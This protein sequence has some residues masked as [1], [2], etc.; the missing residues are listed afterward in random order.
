LALLGCWLWLYHDLF[1]Y[2]GTLVVREDF[3][4]N[5]M[6]LVAIVGLLLWRIAQRRLTLRVDQAPQLVL[7]PLLLLIS[8]SVGY[9]LVARLIDIN[10]L[11]ALLFGLASYGLLGLWISP[12]SWRMGFPAALLL[13]GVLPFGNHMQIF[14]GYPVRLLTAEIVRDGLVASGV[15]AVG[16]DTI[17]VFENGV[18]Q[19]D[20]PCSGV[21][22][23]W[24]GMMFLLAATWL[25][26]WRINVR[27][28]L[29]A[30]LFVGLLFLANLARV[31]AL[32]TVGQ[33]YGW[34][35]LAEML[36]VPLGIVSFALACGLAFLLMRR[37]ATPFA[38]ASNPDIPTIRARP[39]WLTPMLLITTL[40]MA[41]S[42]TSRPQAVLAQ[43]V[44]WQ[45]PATMATEPLPFSGQEFD[46]LMRDGAETVERVRFNWN[47]RTGSLIL[48]TSV[49]RRAHHRPERCFESYG[50]TLNQSV[51]HLVGR[52]FPVRIVDLSD[53]NG[54]QRWAATYW[55]QSTDRIVDD[56]SARF[57][58]DLGQDRER[59]VMVSVLF[60]QHFDLRDAEMTAFYTTLRETV[61]RYLQPSAVAQAAPTTY[62]HN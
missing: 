2:L 13:I 56:Y 59:W 21:R 9:L 57:W 18:S 7:L 20:L 4:L 28:L 17:L 22:S 39:R 14:I 55:F 15:A 12:T 31:A 58:D 50:L 32:I 61:A 43:T 19:V 26:R 37:L 53:G 51:A 29:I 40:V 45:F 48:V 46:W 10:V 6:L 41:L 5:Q 16:V 52:D 42:Y 44:G 30:G 1:D 23:L 33:V 34:H 27:W 24:T 62:K 36:H 35:L 8:A 11:E 47:G 25:E 49:S 38:T 54:K 3:R 60:D